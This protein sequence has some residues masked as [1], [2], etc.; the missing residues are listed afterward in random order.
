MVLAV[1]GV[2]A[3]Y[4]LD[5]RSHQ[6]RVLR[7]VSLAGQDVSGMTK[8]QLEGVIGPLG[9]R[10]GAAP[11]QIDVLRRR[12]LD[13]R[14]RPRAPRRRAGHRRAGH[15]QR[16]GGAGRGVACGR[17]LDGWF[18]PRHLSPVV[19][20]D[21]AEVSSTVAA[22][23]P[24][25]RLPV[26]P[27]VKGDAAGFVVVAGQTGIGMDTAALLAALPRAVDRGLDP[28]RVSVA[29]THPF[30][31]FD[32]RGGTPALHPRRPADEPGPSGF[33]R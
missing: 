14:R 17:W 23:D 20:A 29:T 30:P 10:I 1:A 16:A 26:E 11:V 33:G 27:E 22:D 21:A 15:R 8:S 3:G 7:H 6:G 19:A 32:R 4:V 9:G 12:L 25:Q 5:G 31:S 2:A 13:H 28:V 24:G 18:R